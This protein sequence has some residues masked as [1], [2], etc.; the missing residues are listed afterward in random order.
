[1]IF[2]TI[3]R[4]IK[5]ASHLT[6]QISVHALS[7]HKVNNF[8]QSFR[9]HIQNI[10]KCLLISSKCTLG[11]EYC[12]RTFIKVALSFVVI[13]GALLVNKFLNRLFVLFVFNFEKYDYNFHKWMGSFGF[14]VI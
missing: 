9:I 6:M 4:K 5:T 14:V 7:L 12:C 11:K 3:F 2:S 10:R 8:L 13:C 1:M